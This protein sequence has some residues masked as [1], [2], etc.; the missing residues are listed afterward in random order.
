MTTIVKMSA[1]IPL[2]YNSMH[3]AL[4]DIQNISRILNI[5]IKTKS[6]YQALSFPELNKGKSDLHLHSLKW[7]LKLFK[8]L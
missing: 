7:E 2:S 6:I 3:H 4:P 8:K 5:F 1:K